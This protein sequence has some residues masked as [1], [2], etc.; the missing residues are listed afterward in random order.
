MST[1]LVS[2][3]VALDISGTSPLPATNQPFASYSVVVTDSTGVAQS[4]SILTGIETPVAFA[5]NTPVAPGAGSVTATALDTAGATIGTPMTQS[6]STGA[7]AGTFPTLT[8]ITVTA[9]PL[10]TA[11][12]PT[13]PVSTPAIPGSTTQTAAGTSHFTSPLSR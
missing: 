6:Y 13:V 8:G 10:G 3:N 1:P 5:F 9:N 11:T 7:A 4:P 2:I 12:A